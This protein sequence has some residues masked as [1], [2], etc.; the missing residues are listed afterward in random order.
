MI[1]YFLFRLRQPTKFLVDGYQSHY[2]SPE[3]PQGKSLA[4]FSVFVILQDA[5]N[6]A[7]SAGATAPLRPSKCWNRRTNTLR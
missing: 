3:S 5:I 4:G 2:R 7:G 1:L 6:G